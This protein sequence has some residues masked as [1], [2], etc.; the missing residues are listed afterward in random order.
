[1][2]IGVPPLDLSP[3]A[4]YRLQPSTKRK[5]KVHATGKVLMRDLNAA[6]RF[7]I[8]LYE[9]VEP[10]DLGG[11]V[12]VLSMARRI[13]PNLE[14]AVIAETAGPLRLA[15]GLVVE[16]PYSFG[17]APACDVVVVCGGPGWPAASRNGAL[18]AFLRT[19][20]PER[21]ASVCTG[22]M[23]LAAAGVLDGRTATTRRIRAGAESEAPL[24]LLA[25]RDMTALPAAIVDDVVVTGGGV[26][27]AI[28]T[29]LYLIGR[30]Y[31]EAV[32]EEVARLIEY[33]RA[34]A[35]NIAALGLVTADRR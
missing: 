1:V 10:I 9:G 11:T 17:D 19:Q 5:G 24:A 26:A 12:G 15:G 29:T 31:G 30:I 25:G 2:D 13:V 35:A 22:A 14:S 34:Y 4:G 8:V 28:D 6:A 20:P 32:R 21:L 33:D 3:T 7:G 18:A 27:L 23:I 16:V